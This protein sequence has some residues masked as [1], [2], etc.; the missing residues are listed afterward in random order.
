MVLTRAQDGKS[1]GVPPPSRRSTDVL[2]ELRVHF[3]HR[4]IRDTMVILEGENLPYPLCPCCDI[5]VP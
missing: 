2:A 1:S 3:L 5:L 4:Y